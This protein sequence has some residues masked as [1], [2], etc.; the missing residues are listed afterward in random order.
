[1]FKPGDLIRLKDK[2]IN[3]ELD[4]ASEHGV[5]VVR[6]FDDD[7]NNLYIETFDGNPVRYVHWAKSLGDDWN[8]DCWEKLSPFEERTYKIIHGLP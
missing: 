1:M 4:R 7:E 5:F 8:P 6:R 2:W 3:T